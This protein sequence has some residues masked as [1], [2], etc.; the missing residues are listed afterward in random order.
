MSR[1]RHRRSGDRIHAPAGAGHHRRRDHALGLLAHEMRNRLS[2]AVVG[3]E[4]IKRGDVGYGG[5]VSGLVSRNLSRIGS[6]IHRSLVEV[7]L[8]SGIEYRERVSVAEL[9]EEAEVDGSLEAMTNNLGLTVTMVD[10][11]VEVEVDR[12]LVAGALANLMQNAFKFT[13]R[14]GH[15]SLRTLGDR[16]SRPDR[17][18]GPVRGSAAGEGRGALRRLSAAGRRPQRTGAR[19]VHQPQGR[20]GQRRG[21]CG[22]GICPGQGCIFTIDLPRT[23][24]APPLDTMSRAS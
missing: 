9:M 15:V 24:M 11:G 17:G 5:S 7:R 12:Q 23:R 20:R 16:G 10:R 4:Q 6:L 14:R 13:R 19:P 18:R 1:R 22:C 3:F 2:A 8:H 21:D